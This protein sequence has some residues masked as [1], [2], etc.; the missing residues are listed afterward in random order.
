M[1]VFSPLFKIFVF[2]LTQ[3]QIA[4]NQ[5]IKNAGAFSVTFITEDVD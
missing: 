5:R 1:V 4:L 2:T 3:K